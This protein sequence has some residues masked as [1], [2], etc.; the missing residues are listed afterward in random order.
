MRSFLFGS[1]RSGRGFNFR[2]DIRIS[3]S[4][5][6]NRALTCFRPERYSGLGDFNAGCSYVTP[7]QLQE[8]HTVEL[9]YLWIVPDT[10]DSSVSTSGSCPYDRIVSAMGLM[11]NYTGNWDVDRAFTDK[12]VSDHWPVWAEFSTVSAR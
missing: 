11:P 10:S 7:A 6:G 9:P 8:L 5:P 3:R 12:T 1:F 2:S 4:H